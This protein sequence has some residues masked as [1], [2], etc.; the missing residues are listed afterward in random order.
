MSQKDYKIA[1][2]ENLLT[3]ENH[4]R[5][6]AKALQTNQTTISRKI[7]ELYEGNVVDYR[8]MGKNKVFFLKKNIEAKQMACL[9]ELHKVLVAITKYPRL[10]IVVEKIRQ[11]PTINLAV[12]FGSY[13]KGTAHKDSDIDIYIETTDRKIKEE[14]SHIDSKLS[15]KI[16]LYNLQ[17]LL[18]KEIE[19]NHIVLKGVE[20]YYEKY[21]FF[22]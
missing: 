11:N 17:D 20:E 19:K 6:I 21:S 1:I 3:R 10:R 2:V 22:R 7:K 4:L 13:A 5:G 16:G 14:V 18:I 12:L 8:M 15:V 9:A